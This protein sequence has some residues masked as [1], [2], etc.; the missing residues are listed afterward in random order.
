MITI[1][2]A[3]EAT[4]FGHTVL[5]IINGTDRKW[6]TLAISTVRGVNQFSRN[7]KKRKIPKTHVFTQILRQ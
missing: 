6:R 4:N 7:I 1:A 5:T 2:S 3:E